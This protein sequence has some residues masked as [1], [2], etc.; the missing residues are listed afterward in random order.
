M[1]LFR[2][3]K[4]KELEERIEKNYYLTKDLNYRVFFKI[5]LG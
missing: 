2:N 5:R 3:I 4:S 1:Q